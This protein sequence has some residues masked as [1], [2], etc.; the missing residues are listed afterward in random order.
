MDSDQKQRASLSAHGF[1]VLFTRWI[2]EACACISCTSQ[3]PPCAGGQTMSRGHGRKCE[4]KEAAEEVG[5]RGSGL[6]TLARRHVLS[7][8]NSTTP[9]SFT[10]THTLIH[11]HTYSLTHSHSLSLTHLHVHTHSLTHLAQ[12]HSF[13]CLTIHSHSH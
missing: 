5:Q 11:T 7:D 6:L 9:H 4:Q 2:W 8:T 13:D 3:K 10:L 12:S 1:H